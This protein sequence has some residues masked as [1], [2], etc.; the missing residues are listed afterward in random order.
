MSENSTGAENR[1]R[2]FARPLPEYV[3]W[4]S[5]TLIALGG[6]ALTVG[7][8]ALTLVVDQGLLE[9]GIG[10]G[11]VSVV[12]LE[13][14]LTDAEALTVAERVVDWTGLG[15][16]ITGVGLVAFAVGYVVLRHRAHGRA[17][18]EQPPESGRAYA[19]A[20]AVA[21]A[22]LSFVPLSP[23]LGG[24]VAGYLDHYDGDRSV[25]LGALAG[26]LA[27][28]PA[29]SILLFVAVGLF[30]GL[31]AVPAAGLEIVVLVVMVLAALFVVAYGAGLGALGGYLGKRLAES[32]DR[33]V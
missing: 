7:G 28:V 31:S 14:Q 18:P 33:G 22:V 1:A 20:G 16:L 2:G 21:T 19:V 23:T 3:D 29:V 8:S 26:F 32:N 9:E 11:R 10:S 13:R 4:V 27:M 30:T 12:V 17:S 24:A 15:L 6:L 25:R 5:A